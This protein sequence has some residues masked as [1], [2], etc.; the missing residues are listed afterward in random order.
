MDMVPKYLNWR[1]GAWG[2][3]GRGIKD[4]TPEGEAVPGK[5]YFPQN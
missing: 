4:L 3:Q 1:F 5:V 2:F